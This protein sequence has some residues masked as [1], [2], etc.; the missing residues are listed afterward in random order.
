MPMVMPFE[1]AWEKLVQARVDIS[2]DL[3]VLT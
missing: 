1:A 2:S 3:V